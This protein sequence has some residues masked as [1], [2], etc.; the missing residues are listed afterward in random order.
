MENERARQW[1]A[2]LDASF[3]ASPSDERHYVISAW[4]RE[5]YLTGMDFD[6]YEAID[7]VV[8]RFP[9]AEA[10]EIVSGFE[11]IVRSCV[12]E[13]LMRLRPNTAAE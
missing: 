10:E 12:S 5:I 4:L 8:E 13:A 11:P 9:T 3:A 7:S 2:D 6:L 1:E